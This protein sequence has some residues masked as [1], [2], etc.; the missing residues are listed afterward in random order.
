MLTE[1]ELVDLIANECDGLLITMGIG[2]SEWDNCTS[3]SH[4]STLLE[5]VKDG[6]V[7][8][9]TFDSEW[10]YPFTI[11]KDV[12]PQNVFTFMTLREALCYLYQ[13]F[14]TGVW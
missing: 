3:F 14:T 5:Y 8:R 10:E 13:Q 7:Y 12:Y 11:T 9:I 4:N 6:V 2:W 1:R